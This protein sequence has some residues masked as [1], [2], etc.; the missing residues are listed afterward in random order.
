[1]RFDEHDSEHAMSQR[2]ARWILQ[3]RLQ[4][5]GSPWAIRYR[6]SVLALVVLS[7]LACAS[8]PT[9]ETD[10]A[11]SIHPTA[12]ADELLVVDCL[13]PGQ[14]R[15]LG[16]KLTY[17]TPRR[18][19]KTSAVDCAVRG[20]E[21]TA[22]DR[23]NYATALAVWLPTAENGDPEAQNYV[24]EIYERGLGRA[25]DYAIAAQWYRRA[26]EQGYA[27]AQINLGQMYE[28]GLGVEQDVARALDW[29]ARGAGLE[30][31]AWE[32]VSASELGELKDQVVVRTAE[33]DS[34]R[35]QLASAQ[36]AL[37][38][39]RSQRVDRRA[40]AARSFELVA[41]QRGALADERRKLAFELERIQAAS[42]ALER[43]RTQAEAEQLDRAQLEARAEQLAVRETELGRRFDALDAKTAQL[44]RALHELEL[45][46]DRLRAEQQ[47][48]ASTRQETEQSRLGLA[49]REQQIAARE[50][51]LRARQREL[52]T[53]HARLEA[54]QAE[55]EAQRS[56]SQSLGQA[57]LAEQTATLDAREAELARQLEAVDAM[58]AEL[59]VRLRD[60][61][62]ER[63]G[64]QRAR[65][66]VASSRSEIE[67]SR[68][69]LQ[70]RERELASSTA[71]LQARRR[72]L[73][74]R[75][76]QLEARHAELEAQ[77]Q[78]NEL[79][80]GELEG[81]QRELARE[82]GELEAIS[83]ARTALLDY[84]TELGRRELTLEQRSQDF[85]ARS[86]ELNA[87]EQ[88]LERK[89]REMAEL[90]AEIAKL[91]AAAEEQRQALAALPEAEAPP[92]ALARPAIQMIDPLIVATRD[93]PGGSGLRQIPLAD[94]V[95]ER[96]IVG[97]VVAPAGLLSLTINDL[98][99]PMLP[100]GLFQ[101]TLKIQPGGTEVDV[102]AVDQQGQRAN[103]QFLLFSKEAEP[104][105][106]TGAVSSAGPKAA[107]LRLPADLDLGRYH[108]LVI[109]NDHY[110]ELPDLESAVN[111]ADAVSRVLEKRYG[112]EVTTLRDATRYEILSA[113]NT[114]TAKLTRKDN[115]L[116]YYAGHGELD[117]VNQVG[118]WLPVDAERDNPANWLSTR[119]LTDQLNRMK[120]RHVLVVADSCYSGALTRSAVTSLK[121]GELTEE[122][123]SWIKAQLRLRVR[124]AL[125]S[126]GLKPVL[127]VGDGK[128]S[129]FARSFIDVLERNDGVL[130][131]LTL[132]QAISARVVQAAR[133]LDFDQ[134][135]E[136]APIRHGHHENGHF[137]FVP[138]G[139]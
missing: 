53:H 17:L 106:P 2:T 78:R 92:V 12:T 35:S 113:M 105:A 132:Y 102:V 52:E 16:S 121:A 34:L 13:L 69:E 26:A 108:A 103:V 14:V 99:L 75:A 31:G 21:Y 130:D 94:G 116:I 90:D 19:I 126:G 85:E 122:R 134:M 8:E 70:V 10:S 80:A 84:A 33:A 91:R 120:A 58:T 76:S 39:S 127:D 73:A 129:L 55:L 42:A 56:E 83:L 123:M 7:A 23:A 124:M 114:L 93:S 97:R 64:L 48:T 81:Q 6:V 1:M 30:G 72:E 74:E 45:E 5:G 11:V 66:L 71:T 47:A 44:A 115:L 24:G 77:R 57:E 101:S 60:L 139:A 110:G 111:D 4:R 28:H 40:D 49:E 136:Y 20:G 87:A 46:R 125:T 107:P 135:P 25:P 59:A 86:R 15:R 22:F 88:T 37:E 51:E 18:P 61:E 54:R 68:S 67:A 41:A 9:A 95:L 32:L 119:S 27:A 50:A 38:K 36:R 109:G 29:Y 128:N 138:R 3:E 98:A 65:Q 133:E 112:F 62:Q 82:R 104:L 89:R 100:N 96:M 137:L 79:R 63:D 117:R 43:R 131:G 118:H